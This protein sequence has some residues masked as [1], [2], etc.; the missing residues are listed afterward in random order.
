M[1]ITS[2]LNAT[3]PSTI[4]F[5]RAAKVPENVT[6]GGTDSSQGLPYGEIDTLNV[7]TG[8]AETRPRNRAYLPIIKT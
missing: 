6:V 5:A 8:D 2:L 7:V 4:G 1:G 3:N